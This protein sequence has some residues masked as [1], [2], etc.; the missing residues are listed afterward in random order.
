MKHTILLILLFILVSF[1]SCDN[2]KKMNLLG[3]QITYPTEMPFI[4][5]TGGTNFT[6][7]YFSS[8]SLSNSNRFKILCTTDSSGCTGCKL[9][10][11]KWKSLMGEL[12]PYAVEFLFFVHPK[13]VD[14]FKYIVLNEDFQQPLCLDVKNVFCNLNPFIMNQV[15]LLDSNN[16]IVVIGNPIEDKEV[17]KE[18]V[19]VIK[20]YE[21]Q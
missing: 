3:K 8:D 5:Y 14:D 6:E 17:K 13:N 19:N 12:R 9:Q 21:M 2:I 20:K 15:V 4:I 18:M 16:R 1:F 7:G 11:D 10:L